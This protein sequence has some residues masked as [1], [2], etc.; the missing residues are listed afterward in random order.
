[1]PRR[2]GGGDGSCFASGLF[3]KRGAA[4]GPEARVALRGWGG[5]ISFDAG[6]KIFCLTADFRVGGRGE[7]GARGAIRS[8]PSFFLPRGSAGHRCG[9]SAGQPRP[10]PRAPGL[11][12]GPSPAPASHPRRLP[13]GGGFF[14]G[15]FRKAG[16]RGDIGGAGGGPVQRPV[17]GGGALAKIDNFPNFGRER[18]HFLQK[19]ASDPS[20]GS[21]LRPAPWRSQKNGPGENFSC[22]RDRWDGRRGPPFGLLRCFAGLAVTGGGKEKVAVKKLIG[23]GGTRSFLFARVGASAP[24]NSQ[25][26]FPNFFFLPAGPHEV[27]GGDLGGRL[28]PAPGFT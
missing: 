7:C 10:R 25:F 1:L 18:L 14:G 2:G 12:G 17:E 5:P 21:L 23:E 27:W 9:A 28:S 26:W 3:P 16:E 19:N 24:G 20:A 22:R 6:L 15:P 8:S 13:L 11:G 4:T